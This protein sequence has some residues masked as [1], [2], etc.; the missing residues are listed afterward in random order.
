LT[1]ILLDNMPIPFLAEVIFHGLPFGIS[2]WSVAK[3]GAVLF[4]LA[5]TK[6]WCS[7]ASNTSERQMHSKVVI[8]TVRLSCL[9]FFKRTSYSQ[10]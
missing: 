7:G 4:V 1:G 2:F 3:V 10:V 8:I 5:A 6:W 9:L